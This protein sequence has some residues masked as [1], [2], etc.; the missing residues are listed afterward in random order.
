MNPLRWLAVANLN[1]QS[2]LVATIM[3]AGVL[4]VAC[5]VLDRSTGSYPRS[6]V[7]TNLPRGLIVWVPGGVVAAALCWSF[8]WEGILGQEPF[9]WQRAFVAAGITATTV[10]VVWIAGKAVADW[11]RGPA[12]WTCSLAGFGLAWPVALLPLLWLLAEF[13]QS[14]RIGTGPSSGL[15]GFLTGVALVAAGVATLWLCNLIAI[16]TAR[17]LHESKPDSTAT[18]GTTAVAGVMG[19]VGATAGVTAGIAFGLLML[20][21]ALIVVGVLLAVYAMLYAIAA[22][23]GFMIVG[24][25]LNGD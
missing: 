20:L 10:F 17:R 2:M 13:T 4:L 25:V 11:E 22:V 5:T 6:Y 16:R 12:A 15:Y 24:A 1:S 9:P 18:K 7:S 21:V 3:V 14:D 23:G 19:V 8:L